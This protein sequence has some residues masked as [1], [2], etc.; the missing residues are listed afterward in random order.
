MG[1]VVPLV[2][3]DNYKLV[4]QRIRTLWN[5]GNVI[6]LPHAQQRMLER[7]LDMTDIQ[8]IIRRGTIIE[9]S[10]P[11]NLWRYKIVGKALDNRKAAVVIETDSHSNII[12]TVIGRRT[13]N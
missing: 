7:G 8:H 12:V 4:Q 11:K 5:Q 13:K 6:I 10:F 3:P 1:N 2:Q 9:H